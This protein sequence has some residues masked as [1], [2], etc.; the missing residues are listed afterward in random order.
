PFPTRRS[1]DLDVRMRLQRRKRA[2]QLL[3]GGIHAIKKFVRFQI[4]EHGVARSSG[5]WMGL[6]RE[7]VHEGARA[8]LESFDDARGNENRAQRRVTAS[9]SFANQNQI[10]LDV[11][12]LQG[13]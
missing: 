5:H 13:K 4:V 10:R 7:A 12:V 9:D 6:I 1:S 2:V 3:P 8:M 11:P